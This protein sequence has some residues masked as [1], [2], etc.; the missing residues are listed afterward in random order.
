MKKVYSIGLHKTGSTSLQWFLMHNQWALAEAGILYPPVEPKGVARML[1]AGTGRLADP[2]KAELNEY[3]AHNALAYRILSESRQDFE[4]PSVHGPMPAGF[5]ALELVTQMIRTLSPDALVFAS[6]DLARLSLFAPNSL[7]RFRTRFGPKNTTVLCTIR[8]PDQ[9]ITAWQTQMLRFG[10]EVPRLWDTDMED[11]VHSVHFNYAAA[12]APWIE[13]FPELTLDV[14]PYSEV[15]AMGG[16][17]E[18]FGWASGLDFPDTLEPT[19]NRNIGLHPAVFEI[20]RLANNSLKKSDGAQLRNW[21]EQAQ[22]RINL[23]DAASVEML[24]DVARQH[25]AAQFHEIHNYLSFVSGREAFFEDLDEMLETAPLSFVE[26]A[27]EALPDLIADAQETLHEGAPRDF[28]M[29]LQTA[30]WG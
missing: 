24:G 30:D 21:L 26:A 12:L 19:E 18:Y 10:I 25:L 16:A 4:F 5:V 27:Q 9:A 28:L 23:P 22:S 13:T 20:A 7:E 15:V 17:I 11:Y 2:S 1:A 29:S 14:R 3:M 8:R 6:E